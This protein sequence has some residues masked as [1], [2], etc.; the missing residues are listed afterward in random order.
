MAAPADGNERCDRAFPPVICLVNLHNESQENI[1]LIVLYN[2][3]YIL[4][5][6]IPRNVHSTQVMS[7][8]TRLQ[9]KSSVDLRSISDVNNAGTDVSLLPTGGEHVLSVLY[10]LAAVSGSGDCGVVCVVAASGDR[11]G[12]GGLD[13]VTGPVGRRPVLRRRAAAPPPRHARH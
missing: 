12:G 9:R 11:G 5:R 4:G 6:V 10:S 3:P 8:E 1:L 7:F 2:I 13:L